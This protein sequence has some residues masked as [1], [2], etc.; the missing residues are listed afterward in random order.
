MQ[1]INICNDIH[2][3]VK[4]ADN[5]SCKFKFIGTN[6]S[7]FDQS[8]DNRATRIGV[9]HCDIRL[10]RML[11]RMRSHFCPGLGRRALQTNRPIHIVADSNCVFHHIVLGLLYVVEHWGLFT[12]N[13]RIVLDLCI[14]H[15]SG[16]NAKFAGMVLE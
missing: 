16:D 4:R 11:W 7:A 6:E 5:V 1:H 2:D 15:H 8:N 12:R 3:S 10:L 13:V 9:Q 14:G